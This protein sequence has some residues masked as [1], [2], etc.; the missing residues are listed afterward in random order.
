MRRGRTVEVPAHRKEA[1][2]ECGKI[3]LYIFALI[4]FTVIPVCV[5]NVEKEYAMMTVAFDEASEYVVSVSGDHPPQPHIIGD[6]IHFHSNNIVP[7]SILA[8]ADFALIAPGSVKMRR[9]PE[10]CQW[11]EYFTDTEHED[12]NGNKRTI[13]EYYYVKGWHSHPIISTFFNQPFAHHN[14]TRNP[15]PS[16]DWQVET[17]Q[18]GAYTL[19]KQIISS[20]QSFKTRMFTPR[21]LVDF[22]TSVAATENFRYIG[23][24]YFYSPYDASQL[25]TIARI[26]GMFLEGSLL[27][28]QLSDLFPQCT[29]GDIRLRYDSVHPTDASVVGLLMNGDGFIDGWRSSNGYIVALMMEGNLSSSEM[30]STALSNYLYYTVFFMRALLILWSILLIHFMI[31]PNLPFLHLLLLSLGYTVSVLATIWMITWGFSLTAL[32]GTSSFALLST[33][34]VLSILARRN[35]RNTTINLEK[36]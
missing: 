18:L 29:P 19:G 10:F 36:S 5:Y 27:D 14:P 34:F 24:G 16:H 28:Y 11:Q 6:L 12:S 31:L 26:A 21:D 30:F 32:L 8:D 1:E 9:I 4:F 13:R 35:N 3:L 23:D 17:A 33:F 7:D 25:G 2:Q 15:F 22:Q 20:I